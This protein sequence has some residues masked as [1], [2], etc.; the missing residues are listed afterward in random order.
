[1][2]LTLIVKVDWD[3]AQEMAHKILEKVS[4]WPEE[5]R[6]DYGRWVYFGVIPTEL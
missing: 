2:D 6:E 3:T 1:M 4:E 5:D